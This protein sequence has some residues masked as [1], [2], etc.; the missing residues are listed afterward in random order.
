MNL[1]SIWMAKL[2]KSAKFFMS[3]PRSGLDRFVSERPTPPNI[4]CIFYV[5]AFHPVLLPGQSEGLR[6]SERRLDGR[7]AGRKGSGD[8]TKAKRVM[9]ADGRVFGPGRAR[10][11]LLMG[12][13]LH[14]LLR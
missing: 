1:L 8:N 10:Q 4:G 12:R 2:G 9:A 6:Q 13:N 14:E 5:N 11:R 7:R 3:H